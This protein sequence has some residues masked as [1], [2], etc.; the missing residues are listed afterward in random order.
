[1]GLDRFGASGPYKTVFE[2]F[3]F[4]ADTGDPPDVVGAALAWIVTSPDAE[5]F[6]YHAKDLCAERNLLPGWERR[7]G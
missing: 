5:G 7:S 6:Y 2:K 4:T 3:G 1:M